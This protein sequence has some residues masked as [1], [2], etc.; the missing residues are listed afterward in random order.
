M[1]NAIPPR[2][3]TP[4]G[5]S[6]TAPGKYLVWRRFDIAGVFYGREMVCTNPAH[7]DLVLR[8][9]EQAKRSEAATAA[10]VQRA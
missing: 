9:W 6:K 1:F 4:T 5:Y 10:T 3:P 2:F 8:D 7:G